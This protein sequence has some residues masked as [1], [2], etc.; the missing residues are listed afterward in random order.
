M[1]YTL[2]LHRTVLGGF[3]LLGAVTLPLEAPAADTP[4]ASDYTRVPDTFIY[5][6]TCHGVELR[7]NESVDA[8]RLNGMEDWYL[9]NQMRAFANG[10]RGTHPEDLIGMEMQPQAAALDEKQRD[11]AVAFVTSVP[12]RTSTLRY[13]VQADATRGAT[14]Y[15]TC[16]ACHGSRG[17]GNA[18][19]Q[20]PKLAG[21]SDWY[22]VRQLDKYL[23]GARGYEPEDTQGVQMR[24]A[25]AVLG[26]PEDVRDLVAH[27][28]SFTSAA[29]QTTQENP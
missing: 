12:V 10:W 13:T 17:E 26:S 4:G 18:A 1:K 24:A 20:A 25:A 19:L 23:S 22:L 15:T 28:N 21:Q 11:A 8:P 16:A 5:C 7:G 9:R 3:F 6:T 29:T 2:R 14:L 27:I